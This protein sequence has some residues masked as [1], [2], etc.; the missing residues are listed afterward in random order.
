MLLSTCIPQ[1]FYESCKPIRRSLTSTGCESV[2][3]AESGY[4]WVSVWTW[5]WPLAWIWIWVGGCISWRVSVR[6]MWI[7][8]CSTYF[9]S[10]S[11]S[12]TTTHPYPH[13][14]SHPTTSTPHYVEGIWLWVWVSVWVGVGVGGRRVGVYMKVLYLFSCILR[15]ILNRPSIA[16]LTFTHKHIHHR[17]TPSSHPPAHLQALAIR[18]RRAHYFWTRDPDPNVHY[19]IN[20]IMEYFLCFAHLYRWLSYSALFSGNLGDNFHNY[21]VIIE[22]YF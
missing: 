19:T 17:P 11:C 5:M 8:G 7:W 22:F 10:S 1:R 18:A 20:I 2:G 4:R 21:Q 13:S 9:L 12:P 15:L 14:H 6:W 16:T 3:Q